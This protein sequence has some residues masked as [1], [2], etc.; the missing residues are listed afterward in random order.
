MRSGGGGSGGGG[1]IGGVGGGWESG[2]GRPSGTTPLQRFSVRRSSYSHTWNAQQAR[3]G[4]RATSHTHWMR[5]RRACL[6]AHDR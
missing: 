5:V 1:G 6:D 4:G 3:A 2:T